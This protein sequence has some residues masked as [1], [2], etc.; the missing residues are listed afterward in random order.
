MKKGFGSH[1]GQVRKGNPFSIQIA[2]MPINLNNSHWVLAVLRPNE[3]TIGLYD[4]MGGRNEEACTVLRNFA[5]E[6]TGHDWSFVTVSA[7]DG[8]QVITLPRQ[9]N[10]CDCG[11]FV[12]KAA[13]A[14]SLG[15]PLFFSQSD[16]PH[17]RRRI[18]LE[19]LNSHLV[20]LHETRYQGPRD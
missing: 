5:N 10:G 11:V 7:S 16:M 15:A 17:V 9:H 3:K 8:I 2:L 12:C 13:E 18:V 1:T 19:L 4:S 14:I 20:E 6:V